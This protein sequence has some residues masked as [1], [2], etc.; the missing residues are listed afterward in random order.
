MRFVGLVLALFICGELAAQNLR[1]LPAPARVVDAVG[2]LSP[3]FEGELTELLLTLEDETGAQ[4]GVVVIAST[5]PESIEQYSI[6]LA[7]AWG[8]GR[9]DYDDGVVLVVA[10]DDRRLRIEVGYGLEGV[11]PDA[12]C[13]RVI[14]Q[15]IVPALRA[16]V[17]VLGDMIRAGEV[18]APAATAGT[19]KRIDNFRFWNNFSYYL[20][21]F[22]GTLAMIALI[23]RWFWAGLILPPI[24]FAIP[25]LVLSYYDDYFFDALLVLPLY[26]VGFP[27]LYVFFPGIA[28]ML[29][30]PVASGSGSYRS[31]GSSYSYRPSTSSYSSS[32]SSSYS[33]SSSSSYSGGSFGGGGASGSW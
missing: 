14:D 2:A 21:T 10:R 16:G 5:A 28:E 25:I 4:L 18:A 12:R 22:C 33:S 30:T 3:G 27:F 7:E 29:N 19:F 9:K 1:P 8:V 17:Q 26:A 23:L 24:V 15:H 11:L 31:S 13:K 32:S 20:L 6:R